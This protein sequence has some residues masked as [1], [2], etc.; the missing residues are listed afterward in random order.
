MTEPPRKKEERGDR[1]TA[2]LRDNALR[3]ALQTPPK[4][5]QESERGKGKRNKRAKPQNESK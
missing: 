3:R 4:P 5:K 1:E 2:R